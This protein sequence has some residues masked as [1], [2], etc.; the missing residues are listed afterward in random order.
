MGK[1]LTQK[2]QATLNPPIFFTNKVNVETVREAYQCVERKRIAMNIED[3][4]W[5]ELSWS[6]SKSTDS[7]QFH[8]IIS[9]QKGR[10][11]S[12]TDEIAKTQ[13]SQNK[14]KTEVTT[15]KPS[16]SE[17]EQNREKDKGTSN[18]ST[19]N[20][21]KQSK[22]EE[23][24]NIT[25]NPNTFNVRKYEEDWDLPKTPKV[26]LWLFGAL[27]DS[28]DHSDKLHPGLQEFRYLCKD[29]VEAVAQSGSWLIVRGSD[30]ELFDYIGDALDIHSLT[31]SNLKATVIGMMKWP[32]NDNAYQDVDIHKDV[33]QDKLPNRY[34]IHYHKTKDNHPKINPYIK[35]YRF[36]DETFDIIDLKE[37][38]PAQCAIVVKGDMKTVKL[39]KKLSQKDIPIIL[40][41]GFG[42]ATD[43]LAD[44]LE[45]EQNMTE[46]Q[47]SDKKEQSDLERVKLEKKVKKVAHGLIGK[48][49]NQ[50]S[51]WLVTVIINA[52]K[53]RRHKFVEFF[54]SNGC[55]F[56]QVFTLR[57]M[58]GLYA[59]LPGKV[60]SLKDVSTELIKML[61]DFYLFE[62]YRK[63]QQITAFSQD[64]SYPSVK[65]KLAFRDLF[66]WS[67]LVDDMELSLVFLEN[68]EHP[69]YAALLAYGVFRWKHKND[70]S[71]RNEYY[72]IK[73][74]YENLCIE[75]VK[76]SFTKDEE[77]TYHLLL[78]KL[79]DWGN[80]SCIVMA[81]ETRNKGFLSE[82]AC[83]KLRDRIWSK[84]QKA[85]PKDM[86]D[87][88]DTKTDSSSSNKR[89]EC[90][91]NCLKSTILSPK[92]LFIFDLIGFVAFLIFYAYLLVC[93][94][95]LNSFHEL[96]WVIWVWILVFFLEGFY[97]MKYLTDRKVKNKKKA[98]E[99]KESTCETIILNI[100]TFFLIYK[101][102]HMN[103]FQLLD[104]FSFTFFI[105]AWSL[106]CR[107]YYATNDKAIYMDLA[108]I[109]FSIDYVLYCLIALK[110]FYVS[111][112]LGPMILM[113]SKMMV[114]LS[115]YLIIMSVFFIAFA[116][117]AEMVLNPHSSFSGELIFS[118]LRR[119]YWSA[120]GNYF[121]DE[122][123]ELGKDNTS[124]TNDPSLYS[125]YTELRCPT[126]V[127]RYYV[128]VLMG[129]YVLIVNI[130][131]FNLVIAK[132][133]TTIVSIENQARKVWHY[134]RFVV[135]GEYSRR[136]FLPLPFTPLTI[137]VFA[138]RSR[139]V[140]GFFAQDYDKP[141]K[142]RLQRLERFVMD[143]YCK[144]KSITDSKTSESFIN[145][146]RD[147]G[148]KTAMDKYLL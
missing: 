57:T 67:I 69:I 6:A 25:E 91:F 60:T 54:I 120:F 95:N 109:F 33:L 13:E 112:L 85:Y 82:I 115:K 26:L 147:K 21:D 111:A 37:Y 148:K 90:S 136:L 18:K 83:S 11:E 58:N 30:S 46:D 1:K 132:F 76:S 84:G 105:V 146:G 144:K 9:K 27:D 107:A 12:T 14:K 31:V 24:E 100:Q 35:N 52:V 39:I 44:E 28:N 102:I 29:L 16:Q 99:E 87:H 114:T 42:G 140:D 63:V 68:V 48:K 80:V 88:S 53:L 15:V 45:S 70:K 74:H 77:Q 130:L 47:K 121:L 17:N 62:H 117:S 75:L 138:C 86:G 2:F 66:V 73:K 93:A 143:D 7:S 106:R 96:E 113:M 89:C 10:D 98:T 41:K 92:A 32:F 40:I 110:F 97:K 22:E 128:P 94:L 72:E 133:N 50:K 126:Y 104:F 19:Q 142:K 103:V 101:E 134:Q 8:R 79:H 145:E 56:R 78:N 108:L 135:A 65:N 34:V 129:I 127:G 55:D 122:L 64:E 141:K 23:V 118:V 139:K 4:R 38:P 59:K 116:I 51:Q 123:E 20:E 3:I 71:Q 131:L 61:G 81:I 49:E 5:G 137:L 124:C 125:D 119:A 43:M 36:Q